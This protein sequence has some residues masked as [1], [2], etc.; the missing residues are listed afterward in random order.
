MLPIPHENL[1]EQV[2]SPENL[3]SAWQRVRAND[4]APGIDRLTIDKFVDHFRVQ[5]KSVVNAIRY[6]WYS[7][8]PVKR[9]YIEKESG[10]L[11]GLG[12]P[13]V[14]DRVIQQ[15][16]VQILTPIFDPM[17]SEYSFGFRPNKSQHL[18][19]KQVQAYVK[20]GR[21]IAVDVDLSKFFDRVNHDLLMTLLGKRIRDKSLLKLIAKYLH[22]G[23]VE[24][25]V[26]SEYREGV[27]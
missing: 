16:I 9:A 12:L 18:A 17:F 8:Y 10:G 20:Q 4:G 22:A 25:D 21:K 27:P 24:D 13:T 15:A 23:S 11:R 7:P 14:F 26:W 6:G 1:L 2:L 3:N 19:V 5:G